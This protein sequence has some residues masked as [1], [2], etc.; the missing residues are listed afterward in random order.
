V[1]LRLLRSALHPLSTTGNSIFII[2]VHGGTVGT[3]LGRLAAIDTLD[4]EVLNHSIGR[5]LGLLDT[6]RENLLEELEVLELI[7]LGELDV[8]LDVQ[9]TVIVVA[10]RRHTLARDNLDGV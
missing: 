4:L 1:A 8:E 5:G 2:L 7:L 9:V 3:G 10:E 6:G